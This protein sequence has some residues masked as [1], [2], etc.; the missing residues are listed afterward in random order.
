MALAAARAVSAEVRAVPEV[1]VRTQVTDRCLN[2]PKVLTAPRCP[3]TVRPLMALR[4][5]AVTQK[6]RMAMVRC[7][8]VARVAASSTKADMSPPNAIT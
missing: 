7:R 3:E 5:R 6:N 4:C 1:M 8:A 2:S